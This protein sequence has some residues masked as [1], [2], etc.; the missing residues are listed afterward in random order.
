MKQE[1]PDEL[2]SWLKERAD[3]YLLYPSDRVWKS[4][5]K[6][7]HPNKRWM[8]FSLLL[9]VFFSASTFVVLEK[10]NQSSTAEVISF[11]QR[12]QVTDVGLLSKILEEYKRGYLELS[13][14]NSKRTKN[15]GDVY[16]AAEPLKIVEMPSSLQRDHGLTVVDVPLTLEPSNTF[17]SSFI[18]HEAKGEQVDIKTEE[19]KTVL[20]NAI[21]TV[22]ERAKQIRKKANFQFYVTPTVG[23]RSLSGKASNA[24]FQYSQIFLSNNAMFARD[25]KD[26]VNHS[27]GM[28]IEIGSA[29]L[30]PLSKKLT[31][32]T[33]LQGNYTQYKIR[34]FSSAPEV[35][36]Y[37]M[38]NY[39]YGST[40]ISTLSFYRNNGNYSNTTL[41]N[42]HYM[43]S[44]PVGLDYVVAGNN[45]VNLAIGST[46]QPT[47]VFAQYSYLISTN[48][49]NYAKEPSLNRR[50]N[51]N[52]AVE[53]SLNINRGDLRWSIAPQFRYQLISSFKDKYPIQENIMDFGIKLGVI[54]T[55]H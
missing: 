5:H 7:L 9:L 28:G 53:A 39:G 29:L 14:N 12:A 48:L 33:G 31:F 30:Y 1:R 43:I 38:N 46:I 49:K 20:G 17:A 44:V 52:S 47:Y 24:S 45:K 27:P 51:I 18:G 23:Y 34:A 15:T 6:G 22:V 50:W 4:I 19:K 3:Q 8:Y 13:V 41:R 21:E 40:P 10:R 32:R 37:G 2:E 36:N 25:V 16:D 55:I 11:K 42:E 54:K 26:A 35:A